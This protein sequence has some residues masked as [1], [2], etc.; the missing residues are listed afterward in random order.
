MNHE[1]LANYYF[2]NY[3]LMKHRNIDLL[4]IKAMIPFERLIYLK[5][6]TNDFEEEKN[7]KTA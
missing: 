1:N 7:A 5:L 3:Q 6:L 4:S 2:T